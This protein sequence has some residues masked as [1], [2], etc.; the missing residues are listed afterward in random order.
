MSALDSANISNNLWASLSTLLVFLMTEAVGFLEASE[1]GEG[2]SLLKTPLTS[3]AA[4]SL[5]IISEH[6]GNWQG[7]A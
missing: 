5:C 4:L 6:V 1:L 3:G 7:F 2:Q